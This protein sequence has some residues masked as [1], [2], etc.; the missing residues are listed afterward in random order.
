MHS[1]KTALLKVVND[2]YEAIDAGRSILPVALDMSSGFD[3]IDHD[4]L[5]KRLDHSFDVS[6][7]ALK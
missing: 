7:D 6:G 1:T 5:L 2:M 4:T 3:T